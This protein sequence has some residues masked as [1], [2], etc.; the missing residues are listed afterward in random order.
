ML[1]RW[2]IC[3]TLLLSASAWAASPPRAPAD[4][5]DGLE[6]AFYEHGALYYHDAGGAWNGID[7]EV[8]DEVEKRL[9]C[10]FHR[11][12]DSR[13]RIWTS[14]ANGL[15]DI[16]VS[17]IATPEREKKARF[18]PYL[19]GRNFVLLQMDAKPEVQ[20]LDAFLAEPSYKVAVVRSYTH[21][22]IYEAW[23]NKLRAQ[24]RVYETGDYQSL[25]R[26]FKLRRVDAVLALGVSW[27][28]LVR[29]EE[30]AGQYRIMDWAPN[31]RVV[32]GLVMSRARVSKALAEQISGAVREMRQDGTL[33]AIYDRHVGPEMADM[34]L[35]F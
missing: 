9:G 21:G 30:M 6:V 18:A 3:C 13:V 12:L 35:R 32:A 34:L 23:L 31:D 5:C 29:G 2:L 20:S 19:A 15:L 24:G 14:I 4:S 7:K 33:K 17:G 22:A 25:L 16:S 27:V 28:P 1:S 10:R 11:R 26:L 8:V